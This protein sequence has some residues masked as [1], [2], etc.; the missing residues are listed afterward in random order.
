MPG[1]ARGQ[2]NGSDAGFSTII[3]PPAIV[4]LL[5][6]WRTG[7][8]PAEYGGSCTGFFLGALSE[9]YCL[10]A[11]LAAVNVDEML[12]ELGQL[13]TMPLGDGIVVY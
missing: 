4:D 11:K 13:S 3:F 9:D 10:P 2:D 6:I 1:G 8:N 7:V 12:K 5:K